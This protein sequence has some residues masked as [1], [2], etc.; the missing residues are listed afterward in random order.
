MEGTASVT[1]EAVGVRYPIMS[2]VANGHRVIFRGEEEQLST[3]GGALAPFTRIRGF[4]NL[5]GVGQQQQRVH[6][7]R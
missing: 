3:A 1:I 4:W 5:Q 7:G 2:V 6:A